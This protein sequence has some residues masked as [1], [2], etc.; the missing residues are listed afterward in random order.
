MIEWLFLQVTA[1][2][3]LSYFC[4]CLFTALKSVVSLQWI[5]FTRIYI[6]NF[7]KLWYVC[8]YT[9]VHGSE[10]FFY[11]P[12]AGFINQSLFYPNMLMS[13]YVPTA[14]VAN[15]RTLKVNWFWVIYIYIWLFGK[16]VSVRFEEIKILRIYIFCLAMTNFSSSH[17]L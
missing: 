10:C 13:P 14:S 6:N 4:S 3:H 5:F 11:V 15:A 9:V 2:D 1:D 16:F 7:A 17:F 8:I 12:Q